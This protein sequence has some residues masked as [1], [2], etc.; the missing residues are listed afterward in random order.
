MRGTRRKCPAGRSR[1]DCLWRFGRVYLALL[2]TDEHNVSVPTEE[3]TYAV[4]APE[5]TMLAGE[6]EAEGRWMMGGD[7]ALMALRAAWWAT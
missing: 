7:G 1:T 2:P 4:F 6:R 3:R 5:D